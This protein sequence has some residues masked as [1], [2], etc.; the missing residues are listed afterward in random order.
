MV[1]NLRFLLDTNIL[2]EPRK[3]EPN[4]SVI[5]KLK[6]Y[7]GQSAM[8]SVTFHELLFGIVKLPP[9]KRRV[10]LEGYLASLTL[11]ILPYSQQCVQ[12][13]AQARVTLLARGITL[14]HSD[15]QI[16]SIAVC[17]RLT[18]VTRNLSDF[19]QFPELSIENGFEPD[20]AIA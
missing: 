10:Q 18:L 8:A 7:L 13:H 20:D 1:G 5:S 16:A 19:N 2:S 6:L 11:P 12:T 4:A 17:N 14:P 9:S 15:A 3:P